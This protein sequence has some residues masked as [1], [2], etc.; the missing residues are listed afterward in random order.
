VTGVTPVSGRN[1]TPFDL[2]L[3]WVRASRRGRRLWAHA[4]S[5]HKRGAVLFHPRIRCDQSL[6][7]NWQQL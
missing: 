2:D 5:A 1:V 7:G 6:L 3:R 4:R